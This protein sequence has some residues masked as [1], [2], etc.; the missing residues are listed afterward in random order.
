MIVGV[1]KEIALRYW[2]VLVVEEFEGVLVR[3]LDNWVFQRTNL[4]KHLIRNLRIEAHSAMLELV[5]W[6][7]KS[8]VDADELFLKPLELALVLQLRFLQSSDLVGQLV[9]ILFF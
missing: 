8:L 6:R 9:Q 7:I 4:L 1:S 2:L 5:E 3:E